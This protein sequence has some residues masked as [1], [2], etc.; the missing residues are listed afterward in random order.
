M[1]NLDIWQKVSRPPREALKQITGGRLSGM[2]DVNPQWRIKVMTETFGPCGVGWKYEVVRL[3]TEPGPAGEVM[4]F[5]QVAL[6]YGTGVL[7]IGGGAKD[8]PWSDPVPGIGG[9]AL[10]ANE[11]NGLRANDEAYKMA[12]TDALSVA[13]KQLGV[14]A[15]IYAG[16]WD[17]TKYKD[18]GPP[19]SAIEPPKRLSDRSSPTPGPPLDS[20]ATPP[21]A[22]VAAG[23]APPLTLTGD[24]SLE[25][26]HGRC[27]NDGEMR[28]LMGLL[29]QQGVSTDDLKQHCAATWQ[30]ASKKEIRVGMLGALGEW[31]VQHGKAA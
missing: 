20:R 28:S 3:W 24:L 26:K 27:I 15:D 8:G 6:Y 25:E 4:A 18:G 31:I 22:P 29:K 19:A 14:A 1:D 7:L 17:G 13:M 12:I 16:L 10:V 30:L 5:A 11:K 9:S 2:T 23:S 21:A